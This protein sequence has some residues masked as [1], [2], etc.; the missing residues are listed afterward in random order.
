MNPNY[1]WSTSQRVEIRLSDNRVDPLSINRFSYQGPEMETTASPMATGASWNSTGESYTHSYDNFRF[2]NSGTGCATG[3][4]SACSSEE[5]CHI[6]EDSP[7]YYWDYSSRYSY[8]EACRYFESPFECITRHQNNTQRCLESCFPDHS[9]QIM[10]NESAENEFCLIETK[11]VIP[12]YTNPNVQ[13][14]CIPADNDVIDDN[15]TCYTAGYDWR[16][17]GWV[18]YILHVLMDFSFDKIY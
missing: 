15:S 13:A 5:Y 14:A 7:E 11:E 6:E 4:D 9:G 12:I 16:D 3:G 10:Y 1:A 2:H 8:C 17:A 18:Q